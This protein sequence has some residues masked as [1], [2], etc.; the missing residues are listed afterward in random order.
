MPMQTSDGGK[1]E[2]RAALEMN[3]CQWLDPIPPV[4]AC[5]HGKGDCA[6]CGTTD[7][8]DVKHSTIG[9]RGAVGR[10]RG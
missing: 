3:L 7:R 10:L 6:R 1:A 8:R 2:A 9:G 4:T 5:R